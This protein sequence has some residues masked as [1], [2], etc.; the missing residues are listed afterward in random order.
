MAGMGKHQEQEEVEGT[1]CLATSN[2][3]TCGKLGM[4]TDGML[5]IKMPDKVPP[6]MPPPTLL[7]LMLLP[8][9]GLL[10]C[11]HGRESKIETPTTTR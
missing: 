11:K 4:R 7:A 6:P 10:N 9:V 1:G 3:W 5:A 8:T 2:S